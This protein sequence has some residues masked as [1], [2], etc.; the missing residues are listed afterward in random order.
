MKMYFLSSVIGLLIILTGC[1]SEDSSVTKKMDGIELTLA[2]NMQEVTSDD[3]LVVTVTLKNHND[4]PKKLYVPLPADMKEGISSV[5][6]EKKD[7]SSF[8]LLDPL[9]ST[10]F[11]SIQGRSFYE[12]VVVELGANET[13]SQS[14]T[15]DN[16]LLIQESLE[17]VEAD[18]GKYIV[19]AF[20]ILDEIET[21]ELYYEPEKQLISKL[22]IKVK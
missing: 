3:E 1:S 5:L 17:V 8:R 7:V 13:I 14:F 19:S 10:D 4:L 16:E 9:N 15:W 22:T 12:Y 18:S 21:E 20:V 11:K 6:I 2:V